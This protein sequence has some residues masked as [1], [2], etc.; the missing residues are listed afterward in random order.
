MIEFV[1]KIKEELWQALSKVRISTAL[2]LSNQFN[3]KIK[4]I[5]KASDY[6]CFT[7][8]Y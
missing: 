5:V 2:T 1:K 8:V 7:P 3:Q 4:F 6:I